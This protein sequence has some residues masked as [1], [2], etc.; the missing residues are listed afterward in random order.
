MGDPK[1][2]RRG[3]EAT[4]ATLDRKRVFNAATETE[5]GR[6]NEATE[7]EKGRFAAT[8]ATEG[9]LG[10]NQGWIQNPVQQ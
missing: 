4:E 6:F 3:Q 8:G 5:K 10:F 7:T 1:R 9:S 2:R